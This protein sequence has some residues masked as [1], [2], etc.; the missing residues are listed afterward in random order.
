MAYSRS[1]FRRMSTKRNPTPRH[2]DRCYTSEASDPLLC[3][4][5]S[6][7]FVCVCEKRRHRGRH[8]CPTSWKCPALHC[9][10]SNNAYIASQHSSGNHSHPVSMALSHAATDVHATI[11]PMKPVRQASKFEGMRITFK[12]YNMSQDTGVLAQMQCPLYALLVASLTPEADWATSEVPIK[13]A[14]VCWFSCAILCMH[15][16]M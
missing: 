4:Q 6:L 5:P 12:V 9:Y 7:V 11:E 16:I 2:L 8:N 1:H 15:Q 13:H 10:F 14:D 3:R